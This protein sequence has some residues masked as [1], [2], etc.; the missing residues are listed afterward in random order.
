[1]DFSWIGPNVDWGEERAFDLITILFYCLAQPFSDLT[2]DSNLRWG[3]HRMV[4][5]TG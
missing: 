4:R 3:E 1:L 2:F 5:G